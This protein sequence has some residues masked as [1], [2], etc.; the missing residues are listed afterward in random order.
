[1]C[2]LH[3]T[4]SVLVVVLAMRIVL[5]YDRAFLALGVVIAC[6]FLIDN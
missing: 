2:T 1:M 5:P 3:S 4:V 6:G